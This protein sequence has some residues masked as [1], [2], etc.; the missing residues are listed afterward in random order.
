MSET[1]APIPPEQFNEILRVVRETIRAEM[2]AEREARRAPYNQ[3]AEYARRQVA[4]VATGFNPDGVE[5]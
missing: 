2:R 3:F 5:V 1:P 4:Q